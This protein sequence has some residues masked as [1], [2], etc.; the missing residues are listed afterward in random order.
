[1]KLVFENDLVVLLLLVVDDGDDDSD[2]VVNDGVDRGDTDTDTD[3]V[4]GD[5]ILLTAT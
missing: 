2:G 1:M 4:T 3:D 5:F